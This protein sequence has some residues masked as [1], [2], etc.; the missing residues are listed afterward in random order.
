MSKFGHKI[1]DMFE[2]QLNRALELFDRLTLSL[3]RQKSCLFSL[4]SSNKIKRFGI[5]HIYVCLVFI[6]R[7]DVK[8]PA[9]VL[10]PY[11]ISNVNSLRNDYVDTVNFNTV[12]F[13]KSW[14]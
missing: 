13:N 1:S 7:M 2:K 14:T 8:R 3:I 9:G 4:M 10:H 12:A 6:I 5:V 11:Y